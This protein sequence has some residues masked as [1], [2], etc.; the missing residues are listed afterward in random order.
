MKTKTSEALDRAAH[1]SA[2]SRAIHSIRTRYSLATAS[3]ILLSL[4]IFYVG[5]RIVIIHLMREAEQQVEEIGYDISRLAYRQ[6]DAVRR[7]SEKEAGRLVSQVEAGA[8][9]DEV[10]RGEQGEVVELEGVPGPTALVPVVKS[11]A[12][13]EVARGIVRAWSRGGTGREEYRG[14]Q[15]C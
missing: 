2:F 11:E 12:D 15:I 10:L 13:L 5:G 1:Q 3:F 14:F 7:E 8:K 9:P 4:L 6:A